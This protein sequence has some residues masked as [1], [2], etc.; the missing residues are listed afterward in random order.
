MPYTAN[1]RRYEAMQY[2]RCGKSGLKLPRVSLGLWHN[3][4]SCDAFDNMRAMLRAAFDCGITHI[5]MANNYGPVPGAAEENFGRIF[6][7]DLRPYRD[8]LVLSSK[9]GYTLSLIHI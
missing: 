4:G 5:D 2:A 7:K 1:E 3:F 9:A 8:E 6:E